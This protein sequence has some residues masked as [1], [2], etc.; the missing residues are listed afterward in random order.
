MVLRRATW[1]RADWCCRSPVGRSRQPHLDNLQLVGLAIGEGDGLAQPTWPA[2]AEA[3][4]VRR[5]PGRD[6]PEGTGL[7][8]AFDQPE[9]RQAEPLAQGVVGE[10][11]T[12]CPGHPD[13]H[14]S[15]VQQGSQGGPLATQLL[16]DALALVHLRDQLPVDGLLPLLGPGDVAQQ[17][18]VG[19]A[20][21]QGLAHRA[22]EPV[23]YRQHE[24]QK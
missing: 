4:L 23:R 10:T 6:A 19:K 22:V 18:E 14:R 7:P 2:V 20:Q 9:F 13:A 15:I 24:H 11:H 16:L 1:A 5:L 3:L 17:V 21:L 8:G 12:V